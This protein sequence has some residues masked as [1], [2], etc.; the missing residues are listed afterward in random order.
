[1][2]SIKKSS[3]QSELDVTGK[4]IESETIN[5]FLR[6]RY[7]IRTNLVKRFYAMTSCVWKASKAIKS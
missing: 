2:D 4:T 7:E 5:H 1:M 6:R 3:C